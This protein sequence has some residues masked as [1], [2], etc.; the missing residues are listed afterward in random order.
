[1]AFPASFAQRELGITFGKRA[2]TAK[3]G[4]DQ[5][6]EVG[7]TVSLDGSGSSDPEGDTLTYR[8]SRWS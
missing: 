2:P 7:E 5:T 8:W 1:M 6:V 3:A 4:V